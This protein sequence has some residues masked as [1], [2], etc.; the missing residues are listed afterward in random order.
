MSAG[1]IVIEMQLWLEQN[2]LRLDE[3]VCICETVSELYKINPANAAAAWSSMWNYFRL[4]WLLCQTDFVGGV[5]VILYLSG[6]IGH[7][8]ICARGG[9]W[10]CAIPH[11]FIICERVGE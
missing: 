1:E 2:L 8:S 5:F 11:T 6:H 7:F 3:S 10:A 9:A 4:C